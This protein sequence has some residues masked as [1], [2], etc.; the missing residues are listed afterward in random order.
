VANDKAYASVAP[1]LLQRADGAT[2][3]WSEV[4]R[5]NA[6]LA[7]NG[8][9]LRGI[10]A[11]GSSQGEHEV[12]LGA[13]ERAGRIL[14]IDPSSDF[15]ATV[16]LDSQVLL[17]SR[18]GT[19]RGGRLTAYNRF[20]PGVHPTTGEP[21]HWVTIVG[22]RPDDRN[23]AWLLLR[24]ADGRYVAV[25]V[26]APEVERPLVSTRT[27]EVAPWN[28]REIYVGGY[29]GA[30]NDRRNRNSAWIFRGIPASPAKRDR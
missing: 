19:F 2:P 16:E 27:V 15:K 25:R 30:A 3:S 28:L 22:M 17:R 24:H 6:D 12:I 5:W 29:D 20:V 1:R 13:W 18:L 26:H 9:G 14:C 8:A 4:Y 23:A 11:V 21:I 10:T 7:R